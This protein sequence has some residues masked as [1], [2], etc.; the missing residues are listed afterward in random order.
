MDKLFFFVTS[1]DAWKNTRNFHENFFC[2][3][4]GFLYG[5]LV[6]LV[7]AIFLAICFYFGLA[8]NK[9]DNAMANI[10]VWLAFLAGTAILV[11]LCANYVLIGKSNTL[12]PKSIFYNYSFYKDNT[13]YVVKQTSGNPNE[14]LVTKLNSD[15]QAIDTELNRGKDV[16]YLFSIGCAV[17]GLLFFYLLSIAIKGFTYQGV[18]I[19]HLW[20]HKN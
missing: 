10:P 18:S 14:Q 6:A 7:V 2:D 1:S 20:P 12:N 4:N 8:N 11:F 13:E 16:R 5:I 19:P 3:N 9:R 15:K 17:Y